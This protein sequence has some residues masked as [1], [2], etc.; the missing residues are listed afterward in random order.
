MTAVWAP[1][2]ED[3]L[4][5]CVV[6]PHVFTHLVDHLWDVVAP[7]QHCLET[8]RVSAMPTATWRAC[9]LTRRCSTG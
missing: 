8:R 9:C 4:R 2:H 6:S 1:C 7:D 5:A 3:L